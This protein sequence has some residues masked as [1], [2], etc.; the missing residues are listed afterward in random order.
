M[1]K[2]LSIVSIGSQLRAVSSF[3]S[4]QNYSNTF[5]AY[6]NYYY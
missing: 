4:I 3:P 2:P 1:N 6:K 5:I